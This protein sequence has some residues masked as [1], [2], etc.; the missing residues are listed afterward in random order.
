M[1]EENATGEMWDFE[2][3]TVI[4]DE[5]DNS[6]NETIEQDSTIGAYVLSFGLGCR[7]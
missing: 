5:T 1:P 7:E 6:D 2:E 4:R 3:L